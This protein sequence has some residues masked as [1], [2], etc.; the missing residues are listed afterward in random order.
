MSALFA[1]SLA[2]ALVF[3]QEELAF[4]GVYNSSL[5][6]PGCPKEPLVPRAPYEEDSIYV[7]RFDNEGNMELLNTGKAG[8]NPSWI[9]KHPQ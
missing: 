6:F 2:G 4:V 3:G 7:Y 1:A 8:L 5:D 9:V